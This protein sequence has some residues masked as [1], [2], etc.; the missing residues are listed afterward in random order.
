[1]KNRSRNEIIAFILESVSNSKSNDGITATKIMYS[2]FLSYSQ[3]K[4]Y[5]ALLL[6]KDLLE[7]KSNTQTYKVTFKGI[8]YISIHKRLTEMIIITPKY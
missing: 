2:A 1:M 7:Y 8:H 6:E 5:L 4:E 3:L